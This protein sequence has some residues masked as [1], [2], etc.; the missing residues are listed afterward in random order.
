ML[1]KLVRLIFTVYILSVN[2]LIAGDVEEE[3]IK[4]HKAIFISEPTPL[5]FPVRGDFNYLNTDIGE[6][7]TDIKS[8]GGETESTYL[9][10]TGSYDLVI[11]SWDNYHMAV[12]ELLGAEIMNLICC[13]GPAI[14]HLPKYKLYLYKDLPSSLQNICSSHAP[15]A[16]VRVAEY[17]S[18]NNRFLTTDD[19]I[20]SFDTYNN[21]CSFR[22]FDPGNYVMVDNTKGYLFD[23]GGTLLYESMGSKKE[24]FF[25]PTLPYQ[26]STSAD[27]IAFLHQPSKGNEHILK[28]SKSILNLTNTFLKSIKYPLS[29]QI[30]SY[31]ESRFVRMKYL[32]SQS[33]DKDKEFF[34]P[35]EKGNILT[36]I[37][38]ILYSAN[39]GVLLELQNDELSN[40]FKNECKRE[41][42]IW[43]TARRTLQDA[44]PII[45][46]NSFLKIMSCPSY[47]EV[48]KNNEF[49]VKKRFY[50]VVISNEMASLICNFKG[51]LIIWP[52]N[53]SPP[54]VLNSTL[55]KF[56]IPDNQLVSLTPGI[57]YRIILIQKPKF[58]TLDI[59]ISDAILTFLSKETLNVNV[60]EKYAG[61]AS[62]I[63]KK[64]FITHVLRILDAIL[65]EGEIK[66]SEYSLNNSNVN[67][68]WKSLSTKF[69][70]C[71]LENNDVKYL[72]DKLKNLYKNIRDN[73]SESILLN[74]SIF[75]I[76]SSRFYELLEALI[77]SKNFYKTDDEPKSIK[78]L[79]R[80]IGHQPYEKIDRHPLVV[81]KI[82]SAYDELDLLALHEYLK[83]DTSALSNVEIDFF[84]PRV[85]QSQLK[86]NELLKN[87]W[88]R[89]LDPNNRDYVGLNNIKLLNEKIKNVSSRVTNEKNTI[90]DKNNINKHNIVRKI[91]PIKDI[92]NRFINDFI[93]VINL[94]LSKISLIDDE[95]IDL[96]I[97]MVKIIPGIYLEYRDID[98]LIK[99]LEVLLS[100]FIEKEPT[101]I[102]EAL[103]AYS[104]G[105][106]KFIEVVKLFSSK[107]DINSLICSSKYDI[108]LALFQGSDFEYIDLDYVNVVI[109]LIDVRFKEVSTEK[110]YDDIISDIREIHVILLNKSLRDFHLEK[111]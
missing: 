4:S 20:K 27:I 55:K 69:F 38:L 67:E 53:N 94:F 97:K 81:S 18:Q 25:N 108:Y 46:A 5:R 77:Y 52:I 74:H 28:E 50:F 43:Q 35:F 37:E 111:K 14:I 42:Y 91:I 41:E 39:N 56:P 64:F 16:L 110:K 10:F 95:K 92:D 1:K 13:D 17:I 34:D 48:K 12:N 71:G 103:R 76:L 15:D 65:Q 72:I 89:Y 82:Q 45:I 87:T 51:N 23:A 102:S 49:L 104:K 75:E 85:L 90:N 31:L 101:K 61:V 33:P 109:D 99:N 60:T 2:F 11:K 70:E 58:S 6:K 3:K 32:S 93:G 24:D 59:K 44:S 40:P 47:D 68:T 63:D 88:I 98:E 7:V 73:K 84:S 107:I 100:K 83:Y 86:K 21:F 105:L 19:I 57:N 8:L 79:S 29:R 62:T 78:E 30:F 26:S 9:F 54:F 22:D 106:D 80:E 66:V 96:A 36:S